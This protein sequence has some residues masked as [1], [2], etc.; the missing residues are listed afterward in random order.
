MDL[1][2]EGKALVDEVSQ[3]A[4][5]VLVAE[6]EPPLPMS[7]DVAKRIKTT[8]NVFYGLTIVLCLLLSVALLLN[9]FAAN[10]VA[11]M[12]FFV[13]TTNAMLS[14][15]PRGSL[16]VTV[17]R[18]SE[19]IKPGDIITYYAIPDEQAKDTRLTRI[20]A[21]R[22][23][24]SDKA[25]FRTTRGGNAAPDSMLINM[26][27]VLGVKLFVIPGAGYVISFMQTYAAGF[28]VLAGAFCI[29]AVILRRWSNRERP[30]LKKEKR[31]R[32]NTRKGRVRHAAG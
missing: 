9:S 20:V 21:E 29:A 17:S 12:R 28:A 2:P 32:K 23:E 3:L 10:G 1:S 24:G 4:K 15:V 8:A 25:L 30:E 13:E 26:T 7:A 11:G 16:M 18:K 5:D 22:V 14:E 27:Q 6:K 19:K 31:H